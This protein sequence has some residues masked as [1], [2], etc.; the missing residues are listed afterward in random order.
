MSARAFRAMA[1]PCSSTSGG[2][3]AGPTAGCI[4]VS[5]QGHAH[6][7]PACG[8]EDAAGDLVPRAED[9]RAHPH[10]G[11][12]AGDRRGIVAAHAHAELRDAVAPGD[13]AP[14]GRNAGLGS[15][16]A[17]GMHIR[18]EISRPWI[19]RHSFRKASAASG[20]IP[21]FCGSRPVFTCTKSLSGLACFCIS[22]A[23]AC[24]DLGPVHGVDGIEQLHGLRR[25]VG[26]EGADQVQFEVRPAHLEG[27]PLGL[28]LLHPVLAEHPLP[29]LDDGNDLG[30]VEGLADGD[31]RHRLRAPGPPP[32]PPAVTPFSTFFRPSWTIGQTP[33]GTLALGQACRPFQGLVPAR[34]DASPFRQ[35]QQP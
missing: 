4:A 35:D 31:Q 21:A 24:G 16:S 34:P 2:R 10:M 32:G 11:G 15:S 25:L 20:S 23:I 30:P 19:S 17:G 12:A 1:V 6:H 13:V 9:R 7:P 28:G 14:A 22:A 5:L 29:G 18:P 3:T 8:P 33:V 26:L 27:R